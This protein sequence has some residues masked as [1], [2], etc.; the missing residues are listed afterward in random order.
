M[1][2]VVMKAEAGL[3]S[4][5]VA[6]ENGY[7]LIPGARFLVG[8]EGWDGKRETAVPLALLFY[9]GSGS[10]EVGLSIMPEKSGVPFFRPHHVKKEFVLNDES[11]LAD[12]AA[13]MLQEV[14]QMTGSLDNLE[15]L[16]EK[17][18]A[19]AEEINGPFPESKE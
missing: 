16:I 7:D 2:K 4:F 5:Y 3:R 19:R 8:P 11:F 15:S 12:F 17:D 6:T 18:R 1:E 9:T 10:E 13:E 14:I